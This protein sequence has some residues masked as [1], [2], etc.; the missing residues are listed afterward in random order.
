[1]LTAAKPVA[2]VHEVGRN[3]TV[4]F[5]LDPDI[6]PACKD[7]ATSMG[8]SLADF[9]QQALNDALRNYVGA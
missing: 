9:L 5:Q 1:M 6:L 7:Q 4:T 8:L 2:H 3:A